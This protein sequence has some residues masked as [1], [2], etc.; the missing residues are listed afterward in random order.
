MDAKHFVQPL[1]LGKAVELANLIVANLRHPTAW[2]HMPVPRDRDDEA[3]FLP[4]RD[5]KISPDTELFLGL[6][7]DSDGAE[8]ARRRI[9]AASKVRP[10]FGIATE[11]GMARA[12]T[13]EL[14]LKLLSIHADAAA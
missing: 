13:N 8:G 10:A 7:H 3:Y 12:R 11:C 2:I 9:A 4:L 6:V 1:D 14:V 5:L